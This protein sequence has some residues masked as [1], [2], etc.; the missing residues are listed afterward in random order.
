MLKLKYYS[1]KKFGVLWD[2]SGVPKFQSE[3]G[4]RKT[5]DTMFRNLLKSAAAAVALAGVCAT[6]T[7]QGVDVE[8]EIEGPLSAYTATTATSGALTVMNNRVLVNSATE[9]VYPTG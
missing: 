7:A 5:G 2:K 9:F 3:F 6:A 1:I 8:I 4:K